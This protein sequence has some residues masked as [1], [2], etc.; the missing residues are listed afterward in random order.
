[1][2]SSVSESAPRV[3]CWQPRGSFVS[4][5]PWPH[6]G[7]LRP[8]HLAMPRFEVEGFHE[9]RGLFRPIGITTGVRDLKSWEGS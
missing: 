1:M 9:A 3:Y 6:G 5:F 8:N 2:H 4:T 7:R